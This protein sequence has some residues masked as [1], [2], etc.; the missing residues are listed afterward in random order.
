MSGTLTLVRVSVLAFVV[1]VMIPAAAAA[2]ENAA[3][4]EGAVTFTKDVLPILQ[5]SCQ[6][7]HRPGTAAPLSL[8]TYEEVRPWVSTIKDRVVRRQMPPWHIDRSIGEYVADPSLSNEE[9]ATI[10]TWVDSGAPRGNPADAPPPL[11]L[12][13][14]SEWTYGEP[15]LV[16]EMETGFDIPAEGE[17]FYPSEIVDPGLTEDRYV[18]WVQIIPTA[19]CC[20]HHSHVYVTIPED[21][22]NLEE[23]RLGLGSNRQGMGSNSAQIDLIEYAMGS[24]GQYFH[25]G[26]GKRLPAGGMFRFAPHYHPWGEETHDRQKVGIKFYPKGVVPELIV[27][28]HRIRAGIDNEWGLNR[29]RVEDILLRAGYQ[30]DLDATRPPTG[31]LVGENPLGGATLYSVPPHTVVRSERFWPLPQAAMILSY[32]PHMHFLGSRMRLSA[33]H[34][35]GRRQVLT[36]VL[37]YEQTWQLVYA[38]KEPH[39]FPKGTIL[40]NEAWHDN[41]ANNPHNPDPSSWIG[42]GGR[43]IDEMA[44]G[45]TDIAFMTDEQYQEYLEKGKST[46]NE[47]NNP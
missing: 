42:A 16:V 24:T 36:D 21:A 12:A 18:Q 2:A 33:I 1:C 5:R 38:Y 32:Q 10:A 6:S 27:T 25:E 15:D 17:D 23:F 7:C 26:T 39:V 13:N 20:V 34:P 45:W 4:Q 46:T 30:L 8:L 41:T 19:L 35:D 22:E 9:I 43:T 29:E 3:N 40:H 11:A 37:N 14:L 28:S 44:H 31:A 47:E